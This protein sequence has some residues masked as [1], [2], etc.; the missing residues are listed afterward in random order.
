MRLRDGTLARLSPRVAGAFGAGALVLWVLAPG[1]MHVLYGTATPLKP[2]TAICLALAGL[3]LG[4]VVTGHGVRAVLAGSV[5]LVSGETVVAYVLHRPSVTA[6]RLFPDAWAVGTPEGTGQMTLGAAVSLL[7]LSLSVLTRGRT[8]IATALSVV[9]FTFPYVAVVGHLYGVGQLYSLQTTTGI[10]GLT[11]LA[12]ICLALGPLLDPAMPLGRLLGSRG[13]GGS[14]TRAL[15]PWAV[16]VPPAAGWLLLRGEAIGWYSARY[17]LSLLVL[18]SAASTVLAVFVGARRVTRT[19]RARERAVADLED[20]NAVL[21]ERVALAVAEAE[22]GR[23]RRHVL[24]ERTPVGIFGTGPDGSRRFANRRWRELA[25]VP[26][27]EVGSDWTDVLHPD[28]RDR[29]AGLWADSIDSGRDLTAR[30]R[31]LRPDGT[32]TWVDTTTTAMR[33]AP[34]PSSGTA[35]W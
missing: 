4:G 13:A 19:D 33:G 7:A 15:L 10:A 24:L 21:T 18:S 17:G 29:V 27:R 31:Y 6:S 26:A 22:E 9:G 12:V 2:A 11:A 25:G 34:S 30:Y 1:R 14:L 3:V 20:L 35:P 23:E 32:V 8:R 28:D 16:L 5:A